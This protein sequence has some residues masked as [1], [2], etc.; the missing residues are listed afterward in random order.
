[1]CNGLKCVER[2]K[3]VS[4]TGSKAIIAIANPIKTTPPNLSGIARKIA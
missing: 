1:M 3:E 2:T 4:T